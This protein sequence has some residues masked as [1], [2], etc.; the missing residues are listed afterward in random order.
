MKIQ[1]KELGAI[2]EGTIDLDKKLIFF[3]GPNGTGK[4]YMSYLIYSLTLLD[5]KSLGIKLGEDAFNNLMTTNKA[6]ISLNVSEIWEYRNNELNK[7]KLHLWRTFAIAEDKQS[8]FFANTEINILETEEEFIRKI[9]GLEID[10]RMK[11][12]GYDISI[13]KETGT[14]NIKVEIAEETIKNGTFVRFLIIMLMPRLY[15][16]LALYPIVSS[17]IFPVERNSI[18]TFSKELSLSQKEDSSFH[19]RN[20]MPR[21]PQPIRDCLTIAEDLDNIQKSKSEYYD[22]ALVIENELL[23]GK[24]VINKEGN[25]EFVSQKA[26]KVKLSFHQSASIVKTLSS[27]VIYLKHIAIKGDLLIIDEP[28][29]NLHPNN[30][31]LLT[32]IFARLIRR[33]L[34][35]I[36]STHSDYIIR[37]A[38]NLITIGQ[39]GEEMREVAKSLGYNEDEKIY[40]SEVGA[41]IFNHKNISTKQ[42]EVK[43]IKIDANGFEVKT[44]DTTI[45]RL[46]EVSEELFYTLRYGKQK[47]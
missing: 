45:D 26:K 22:F 24:V 6:D 28:E 31:V 21:Y 29:L 19:V 25:V 15:A 47:V 32:R 35:L 14:V 27:L 12:D 46:N 30:Q 37:E 23:K 10:K 43:S 36:V 4:T 13:K 42:V 8:D 2:K 44:L 7:V 39:E 11:I 33:G 38:N 16:I 17:I 40:P 5:N 1:V 34:R 9:Y 20:S 3:C 41:Y 18:Y